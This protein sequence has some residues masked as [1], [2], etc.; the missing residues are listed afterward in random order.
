MSVDREVPRIVVDGPTVLREPTAATTRAL[1]AVSVVAILAMSCSKSAEPPVRAPMKPN[2]TVAVPLVRKTVTWDRFTGRLQAVRSVEIR[3]RVSGYLV[4]IHF[5]EGQIV[6]AGDPLFTI[7]PRPYRATLAS[8]EAQRVE[9]IARVAQSEATLAQANAEERAAASVASLARVRLERAERAAKSDAIAGE[10]VDI[11]ASELAQAVAA[12]EAATARIA[13]AEASIATAKAM[14]AT[15]DAAIESARLDVDFTDIRAPITGRIGQRLVHEGNLVQG[16]A[17]GTTLLTTIVSTDPIHCEFE[18]NEQEFLAYTRL[19]LS[20]ERQSS[21][22]VKNPVL[23]ALQDETGYPHAGHMDFVDNQID[24]NSGTMR[25]R[26]IFPNADGVLHPGM[27]ATVRLPGSA[28]REFILVPDEAILTDQSDRLVYVLA[29]GDVVERRVVELGPIIDGLRA[30]ASGLDP[31][32]RVVVRG[33]QRVRPGAAVTP[34][35][36][37]LDGW[38]EDDGLPDE[39]TPV[40]RERWLSIDAPDRDGASRKPEQQK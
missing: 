39:A 23:L 38:L 21:R 32:A 6:A 28:T 34:T 15:A 29:D 2:V 8:A 36:E 26:A 40:P 4:A 33:L 11:R 10:T 9:A 20:G 7:D 19:A 37:S 1:L 25:G 35:V 18:A 17:A 3:A 27:F 14:I 13:A 16:G 12:E 24:P 5:A 30:V 31:A 22:E